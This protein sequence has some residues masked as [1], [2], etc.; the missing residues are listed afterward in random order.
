MSTHYYRLSTVLQTMDSPEQSHQPARK[1]EHKGER[2]GDGEEDVLVGNVGVEATIVDH[3]QDRGHRYPGHED[4]RDAQRVQGPHLRPDA[5]GVE[6]Q[7]PEPIHGEHNRDAED[8]DQGDEDGAREE[9]SLGRG[10]Q[11]GVEVVEQLLLAATR[12]LPERAGGFHGRR[13]LGHPPEDS[14]IIEHE[15]VSVHG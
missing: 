6:E 10:V 11:F 8:D 2:E 4:G 14:R 15:P 13:I 7:E 12:E 5:L 1:A 9:W 3:E